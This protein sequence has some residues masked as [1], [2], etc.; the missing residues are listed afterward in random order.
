MSEGTPKGVCSVCKLMKKLNAD[1]SV[2]RHGTC[3]GGKVAP[4]LTYDELVEFQDLI[5]TQSEDDSPPTVENLWDVIKA[6][7]PALHGDE[8][9]L[10]KGMVVVETVADDGYPNLLYFTS[11]YLNPWDTKGMAT[12]VLQNE[13][14]E[15]TSRVM[16]N[17]IADVQKDSENSEDDEDEQ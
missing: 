8:G 14:A 13:A 2:V 17:T 10:V 5:R 1:G 3:K 15:L 9:V 6:F 12:H 16:L 7:W 4:S 11:P